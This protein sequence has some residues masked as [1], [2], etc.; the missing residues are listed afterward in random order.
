MSVQ[1]KLKPVVVEVVQWTGDNEKELNDFGVYGLFD[2]LPVGTHFVKD[3]EG[4]YTVYDKEVFNE[5]FERELVWE[6]NI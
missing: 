3:K 1:Y 4:K 2:A 5:N 6:D